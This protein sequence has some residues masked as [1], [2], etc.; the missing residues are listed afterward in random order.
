MSSPPYSSYSSNA[1]SPPYPS[2][3]QLPPLNVN[4]MTNKKRTS[5]GGAS[6]A[7]KR[8]KP[9][10]M[11]A[12]SASSHP[13]RQTSFPPDESSYPGTP[14]GA[15]SPSID[16][17]SLV[18]GSQAAAAASAGPV[19]KKRG[20]KSKADKAREQTPALTT[21]SGAS[22]VGKGAKSARG[23]AGA[24]EE[25]EDREVVEVAATGQE[26]TAEQ[27]AE[28]HRLRGMLINAF[29]PEQFD[30]YENWRAAGLSKNAVKRLVNATVSQSV[31]EPVIIGVRSV[32]KVFIGDIIEGARRV[33]AEWAAKLGEKQTDLPTPEPSRR[34]SPGANGTEMAGGDKLGDKPEDKLTEEKSEIRYGPLRPDH[35]REA[36]R[37]YRLSMEGGSVGMHGLWNL[38]QHN[39][40]ERFGIRTRGRRLFK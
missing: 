18:S 5:E 20:R 15:R 3:T 7:L 40:V 1:R 14:Y 4:I 13:L 21:V 39:G 33:Q 35:L 37:R 23:G 27:K 9:S 32:A 2:H 26:R 12:T 38:Q 30:R 6:P 16:S 17:A 31:T 10:A 34:N 24:E 11:S 8:R 29:T 28:E 19:K 25:E 36:M 22:D